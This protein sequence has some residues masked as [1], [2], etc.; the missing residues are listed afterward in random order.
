MKTY[1]YTFLCVLAIH[2]ISCDKKT[3][4]TDFKTG[5]FLIAKD[6]LFENAATL[7]KTK[8]SQRQISSK[9]DTLFANVKWL[10]DC[11]YKLTFDKKQMHLT[12]FH[13]NINTRG[14]ILVEFGMPHGDIMPYV[15][16][17]KG[18]TKTETFNGYLKK[19]K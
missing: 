6:T 13:I 16:V 18:E 15:S 3:A 1:I 5:T 12:P 19:L 10:N 8:T 17:I 4:C 11:S 14:G 2:L 7:I 9:G